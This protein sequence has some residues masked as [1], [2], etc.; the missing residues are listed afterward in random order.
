[1][2]VEN[3]S[4]SYG[5]GTIPVIY[6]LFVENLDGKRLV[7]TLIYNQNSRE[8]YNELVGGNLFFN[9]PLTKSAL[10]GARARLYSPSSWDPGSSVSHLDE[11]KTSKENALM[12]PF[13]DRGKQSM[14]QEN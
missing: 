13:I 11:L 8:L 9:G 6:D 4:G 2:D 14:I 10:S 3:N 12:T 5:L 1:M 7:D